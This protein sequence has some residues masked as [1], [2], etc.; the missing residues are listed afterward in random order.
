MAIVCSLVAC[1]DN[2]GGR[3]IGDGA[4]DHI[5]LMPADATVSLSNTPPGGLIPVTQAYTAK[6]VH[7]DGSSEDVTNT[8]TFAFAD[9]VYGTF[10][11]PSATVTGGGAGVVQVNA[12]QGDAVG[13]TTLTVNVQLTELGSGVDPSAPGNFGTATE[14][15]SLAPTIVYPTDGILVPPNLGKFD[16][17]WNNN[18]ATNTAN[19]FLTE[20]SNQ[21]IDVKLFTTGLQ[22]DGHAFWDQYKPDAWF[23]IASSKLQLTL[24]VAGM[25]TADPTKKGTSASQKVDVTNENARGG[26]YYWTSTLRAVQ[27]YDIAA[28]DVDPAPFFTGTPPDGYCMGCHTLSRDGSKIAMTLSTGGG[29]GALFD[30]GTQTQIGTTITN[31]DF[32]TFNQNADKF[33]ETDAAGTM[34]LRNVADTSVIAAV[35]PMNAGAMSAMPEISP[36][37]TMM[38]N[39]EYT[40][41]SGYDFYVYD[42]SIVI[43]TFDDATNTFGTPKVLVQGVPRSGTDD[44]TGYNYYPSFSPDSQWV[45]F[46][47]TDAYSYNNAD[48]ETWVVKADG[49]MP[50]IRL[51]LANATG[52]ITNSWPRWVPFGQT[53]GTSNEPLFYL[54]F[55]STRPYG[56][57]IPGGG[58]PQ[59]WMTP[60]FVNKAMQGQDPTGVSFRVP[61][62]DV[63]T[64]NH[65]AQWT[66]QIVISRT[67]DGKLVTASDLEPAAK[68][69][70]KAL[71]AFRQ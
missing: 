43:R 64:N 24:S 39:M 9:S 58:Q 21:Y 40:N 57:R 20:I 29:P 16:V 66:Q 51:S 30:V 59:I 12:I 53:F 1:D 32:A 55:S 31:W 50:P 14:D 65:I 27:R 70:K 10:A 67:T 62:Q 8:A 11:G 35:P 60:F 3:R 15:P 26:I 17:H 34:N 7:A 68:L 36:D 22:G 46:T 42:G 48:A 13:T 56:V 4:V 44:S 47:R 41:S 38:V 2:S 5:E 23:P 25:N 6:L 28:P 71:A 18:P 52:N 33:V 19:L 69:M 54:T 61:F 45:L 37:N 63:T 49:T